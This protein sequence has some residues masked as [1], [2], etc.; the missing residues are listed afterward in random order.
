MCICVMLA[1]ES[2][3][4]PQAISDEVRAYFG[5]LSAW[6]ASV[7]EQGAAKGQLR[8]RDDAQVDART[9]MSTVH[10]AMLTARAF[11]DPE[12]FATLARAAIRQLAVPA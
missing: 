9:F 7:L 8:L 5:D 2:P 10:G 1:A 3:M 11:D 4:I 6:L 12:T